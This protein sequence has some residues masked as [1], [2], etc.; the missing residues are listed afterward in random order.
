MYCVAENIDRKALELRL[1]E[2]GGRY[3]V[4]QFPDVLYGQIEPAEVG[5]SVPGGRERGGGGGGSCR[6]KELE[7]QR[8]EGRA[9]YGC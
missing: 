8:R 9:G 1:R 6:W 3:L 5:S 4:Q 7:E 2:R